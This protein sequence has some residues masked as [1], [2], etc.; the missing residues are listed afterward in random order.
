M[1]ELEAKRLR[2][3][4]VEECL[5]ALGHKRIANSRCT[6]RHKR[7][8]D[9]KGIQR[10]RPIW[11]DLTSGHE[12]PC[13]HA[14]GHHWMIMDSERIEHIPLADVCEKCR[15]GWPCAEA[16]KIEVVRSPKEAL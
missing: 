8:E 15:T 11:C 6:A 9:P 14:A 7:P 16:K 5:S 10:H 2:E 4:V 3:D 12:G 13:K 1:T